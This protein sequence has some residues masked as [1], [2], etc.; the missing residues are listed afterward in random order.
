MICF[1]GIPSIKGW[2]FSTG[3]SYNFVIERDLKKI[4]FCY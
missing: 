4:I 1:P 3:L 2:L